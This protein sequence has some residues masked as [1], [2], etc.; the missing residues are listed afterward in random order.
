MRP[1]LGPKPQAP[2]FSIAPDCAGK[3]SLIATYTY[4]LTA[5]TYERFGEEEMMHV[6]LIMGDG[7]IVRDFAST[8][9][10]DIVLQTARNL[11]YPSI[12]AIDG[13]HLTTFEDGFPILRARL[14][15]QMVS[16]PTEWL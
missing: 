11:G 12:M 13:L 14:E 9:T 10:G 6:P 2:T 7:K 3:E 5:A 8:V 15:D 1:A 4:L 16:M